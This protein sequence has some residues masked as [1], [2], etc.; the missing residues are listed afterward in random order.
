M[1]TMDEKDQT[2]TKPIYQCLEQQWSG[3]T[4]KNCQRLVLSTY[5]TNPKLYATMMY[6]E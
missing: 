3:Q 6:H 5:E 2:G 1:K 4:A